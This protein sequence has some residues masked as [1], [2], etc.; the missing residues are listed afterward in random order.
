[1]A[2]SQ[3]FKDYIVSFRRGEIVY[4]EGDPGTEMYIVQNG[5][6]EIIK[7]SGEAKVTLAVMEKGDFFGEMALIESEPHS[8]SAVAREDC[9]L[10]EINSTLFD[11]MIRGNI[12]IAV[13]MLRK[14]SLR[15]R[16]ATRRLEELAVS[17]A[18]PSAAPVPA[19]GPAKAPAPAESSVPEEPTTISVEAPPHKPQKTGSLPGAPTAGPDRPAGCHAVL[20]S[21]D[22]EE[23][24]HLVSP[25]AVIGRFDPVTGLK[26]EVDLSSVD[27]NRSV[28]RHHARLIHEGDAYS[29]IEEVGALN[30]TFVNG[31]QLV[32]GKPCPIHDGDVVNLGMVK[33]LFRE[34]KD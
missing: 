25:K 33:L 31:T 21:E 11:K 27:L 34:V 1:M 12:E 10:I 4:S 3:V 24:F 18:S 8:S 16:D 29:L 20:L 26:P 30:G 5:S 2:A 13:R 7:G 22:G 23:L 14:L 32:S 6:V 9:E 17:S 19:T 28:S 15:L